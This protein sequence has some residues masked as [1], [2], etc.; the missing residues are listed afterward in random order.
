M[1]AAV[2][3]AVAVASKLLLGDMLVVRMDDDGVLLLLVLLP[4]EKDLLAMAMV[5]A[6]RNGWDL[7]MKERQKRMLDVEKY[8]KVVERC[9]LI[10]M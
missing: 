4:K 6:V 10:V 8:S 2:A 3:V 1:H 7:W 9:S 5:A